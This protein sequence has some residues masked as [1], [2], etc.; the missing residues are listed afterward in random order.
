VY[1]K[2][3]KIIARM[4]N[5][6]LI[7][8]PLCTRHIYDLLTRCLA[9]CSEDYLNLMI[10]YALAVVDAAFFLRCFPWFL[11]PY[12]PLINER[13]GLEKEL[14]TDYQNPVSFFFLV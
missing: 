6:I 14:G 3:A 13:R 11:R 9:A 4:S 7:G 8:L 2:W 12:N 5:R 10:A 1:E